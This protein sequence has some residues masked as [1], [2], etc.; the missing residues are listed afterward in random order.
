MYLAVAL[1]P[2]TCD[3]ASTILLQSASLSPSID[4]SVAVVG[5]ASFKSAVLF[6]GALEDLAV[7]A[8]GWH[9]LDVGAS[10]GGFTD[11]LLQHGAATVVA[12]DVGYGQLH[13]KLR[14]DSRVR[15]HER[16]NARE[17]GPEHVDHVIDLVVVDA[18]F[19]SLRLLLPPVAGVAPQARVLA[20]VKPQFEARREKVGRGGSVRDPAV[21][22]EVLRTII[23]FCCSEDSKMSWKCSKTTGI[24]S[25]RSN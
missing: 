9:C 11:C 1:V 15:V 24:S 2:L 10:T 23:E 18:S 4:A 6:A 5:A 8:A 17:L 12:V 13:P 25:K 16:T 14:S 3:A 7:D 20:L 21:H 19:I 22:A